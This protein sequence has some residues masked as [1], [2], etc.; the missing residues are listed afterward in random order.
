MM[1]IHVEMLETTESMMCLAASALAQ[2]PV[3]ID[4]YSS[5]ENPEYSESAA[6]TD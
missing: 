5:V 6:S 3:W 4:P 2:S 1:S